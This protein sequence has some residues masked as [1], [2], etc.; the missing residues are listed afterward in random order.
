MSLGSTENGL[1][2]WSSRWGAEVEGVLDPVRIGIGASLFFMGV[3]RA[4]RDETLLSYGIEA[5]GFGRVDI[6]RDDDY[7]L[8]VRV[9]IDAGA[10]ARGG[11]L[12]WGPCFGVGVELGARGKRPEA[13]RAGILPARS[14]TSM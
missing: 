11:S 14:T 9:G 1:S 6:T 7:A 3:D 2:V 13:W 5:R 12:F 10:E 8:F 4:E